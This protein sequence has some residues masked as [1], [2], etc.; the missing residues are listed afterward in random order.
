[1]HWVILMKLKMAYFRSHHWCSEGEALGSDEGMVHGIG[2]VLGY[3]IGASDN[4]KILFDDGTELG[5]LVG[6]LE[7]SNVGIRHFTIST[8]HRNTISQ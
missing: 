4:V 1:M 6:Y 8:F 5:F 7:G 3:T 2:G